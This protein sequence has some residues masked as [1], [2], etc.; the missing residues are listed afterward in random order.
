VL[1]AL[2]TLFAVL[3][4]A[5]ANGSNDVS[6]GVATLVGSGRATYR[7][8]LLWG[9]VWTLAGAVAALLLSTGLV[10]MFITG[11]VAASVASQPSFPLAVAA[12]ACA[13]VLF[14]S[15]TGLPVSTTHALTGAIVGTG[16]AISGA[17]G[18]RWPVLVTAVALPLALSPLV[19]A[20]A[21]AGIQMALRASLERAELACVCLD[22][23]G[24]TVQPLA[25]G[26][27]VAAAALPQL[28]A[29]LLK[30][31]ETTGPRI[32]VGNA[33][34]WAT[35]GVLSFARG[36][37]D[38]PKIVAL[39]ALTLTPL[40]IPGRLLFLMTAAA[41]AAGSLSGRRVTTTLAERI[42]TMD[43]V[44][45]LASSG[46]AAVIVLLASI[47][48]LPVSTTHVATGAIVGGGLS[49]GTTTVRWREVG[50]IALAWVVT[51]PVSA[52]FSA[53]A[54]WLLRG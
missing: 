3:S 29:D 30:H 31:C 17:D 5:A 41:M 40:D 11:L 13:W 34:H 52:A 54:T 15:A 9:T 53:L 24:V 39:A 12:G 37:N 47:V 48:A 32:V 2:L 21:S 27:A 25:D 44:E 35:S 7:T 45:G 28:R 43:P 22:A 14:A 6:K 10:G 46:T 18:V 8:A 19:A 33:L 20:I 4:L 23:S 38:N 50:A 51:L 16:L 49:G 36:L 42:T 26:S 1:M